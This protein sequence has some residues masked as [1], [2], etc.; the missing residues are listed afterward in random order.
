[1]AGLFLMFVM[2]IAVGSLASDYLQSISDSDDSESSP[3]IVFTPDDD[4]SEW[5]VED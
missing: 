3:L 4:T 1:M 2:A 5:N